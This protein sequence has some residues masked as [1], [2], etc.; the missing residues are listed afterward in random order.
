[1]T[2]DI[3]LEDTRKRQKK[4]NENECIVENESREGK[5]KWI[6]LLIVAVYMFEQLIVKIFNNSQI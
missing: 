1:M 6:T 2:H 3:H 4:M 5:N